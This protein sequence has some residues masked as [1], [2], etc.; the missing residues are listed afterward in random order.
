MVQADPARLVQ[1]LTILVQNATQYNT[2]E[3]K[4]DLRAFQEGDFVRVEVSDTG[5]GI[6]LED[7]K[8]LF[9]QFFRS[10][11]I[12]VREQ[13]G[14]GLGLNLAKRLVELMGGQIGVQSEFRKGS[15]FWFTLPFEQV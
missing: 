12:L 7:Q 15:L 13:Q 10:E 6:N 3:G 5:F 4:I 11:D 2:P 9:T 1:V 8:F 14:W